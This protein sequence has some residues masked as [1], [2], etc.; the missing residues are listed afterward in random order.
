M[1]FGRTQ[2]R[3]EEFADAWF[4]EM[5]A[6][7]ISRLVMTLRFSRCGVRGDSDGDSFVSFPTSGGVHGSGFMPIGM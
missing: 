7:S 4:P 3:N 1:R 6:A 5:C 2:V